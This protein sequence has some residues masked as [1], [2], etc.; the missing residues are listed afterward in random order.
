[1]YHFEITESQ[2]GVEQ[3]S[4]NEKAAQK[5]RADRLRRR[6]DEIKSGNVG[7]KLEHEN[8]KDFIERRM[9]EIEE[10]SRNTENSTE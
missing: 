2:R 5:A 3:M 10:Q 7:R 4:T 1:M 6:I 8:P 9:R